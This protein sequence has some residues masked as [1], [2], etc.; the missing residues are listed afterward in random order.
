MG[1]IA[2]TAVGGGFLLLQ[3]IGIWW[4]MTVVTTV[5]FVFNCVL[6]SLHWHVPLNISDCESSSGPS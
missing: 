4:R 3:V 5:D 1:K 2:A 6:I